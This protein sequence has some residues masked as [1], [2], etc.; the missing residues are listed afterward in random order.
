MS[1]LNLQPISRGAASA[2]KPFTTPVRG[3]PAARQGPSLKPQQT[4]LRRT[5]DETFIAKVDERF[6]LLSWRVVGGGGIAE[7][8]VP[9]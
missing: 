5:C 9:A 4:Q 3:D 8:A 6:V 2:V 7:T 1:V